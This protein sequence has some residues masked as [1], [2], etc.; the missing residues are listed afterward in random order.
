MNAAQF[1]LAVLDASG[2]HLQG[3]TLLQKKGYFVSLLSGVDPGL[4]YDAHYYGPYST[5]V[6][7]C[8]ARLKNLAFIGEEST[9]FGIYNDGFELRRF[10]YTIT[11][12]GKKLLSTLRASP[13]Y[14]RIDSAVKKI[15][16]AGDPG[17][18][19]LSIAAKAYFILDRKDKPMSNSEIR[20]EAEKF[21]WNIQQR[22]L[23]K[24][25]EFLQKVELTEGP[26]EKAV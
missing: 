19:E 12:D 23:E 24:A 4:A 18:F 25:V 5:V 17:Y 16:E 7:T 2:G 14:K 1:V 15:R 11:S 13:E 26:R 21:N 9:G 22:S 6:D 20:R 3:R 10:D 8:V